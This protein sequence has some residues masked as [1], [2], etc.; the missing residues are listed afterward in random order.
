MSLLTD[1]RASATPTVLANITNAPIGALGDV[2]RAALVQLIINDI[3]AARNTQ[4][5]LATRG[6]FNGLVK[7]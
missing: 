1:Y 7:L 3:V 4:G 2:D 5:R 6:V